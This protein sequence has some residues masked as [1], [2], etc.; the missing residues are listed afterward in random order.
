[1]GIE[2][3]LYDSS[4]VVQK[5]FSHILYHYK[6][7]VHRMD[8]VPKLL[9]TIQ[10]NRPDIIFMDDEFSQDEDL[11]AQIKNKQELQNIPIIFMGNEEKGPKASSGRNFLKKPISA[12]QLRTLIHQFVPKTKTH[13]LEKHLTFPALP[14]FSEEE[15]L[16]VDE[17]VDI[18][19]SVSSLGAM[20]S[21]KK[22]EEGPAFPSL[23]PVDE[24]VDPAIGRFGEEKKNDEIDSIKTGVTR[25]PLS[26]QT[27]EETSS[28]YQAEEEDKEEADNGEAD[29]GEADDGEADDGEA[30]DGEA[31]G[32][33]PVTATQ[34]KEVS[35]SQTNLTSPFSAGSEAEP[36]AEPSPE[37]EPEAEV[38]PSTSV[39]EP[40][41]EE[42]GVDSIQIEEP[43]SEEEIKVQGGGEAIQPES[44][45]Q[46]ESSIPVESSA[47]VESSSVP[48][49]ELKEQVKK[50][51]EAFME[52][53]G[54]EIAQKTVEKA[55]WEVVPEL[56][57]QMVSSAL[58]QL[59]KEEEMSQLEEES[60]TTD[61]K[62]KSSSEE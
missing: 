49:E 14:D 6:P 42:E 45:A 34:Y 26:S 38:S 53:E 30:D 10:H 31:D 2:I 32:I 48:V 15:D 19:S 1:M 23:A 57:R 27:S 50:E 59:L 21:E 40:L 20:A 25:S 60:K 51:V 11:Q 44:S 56:A 46:A 13:I 4:P 18:L 35:F 62:N 52:R 58:D 33:K 5:I 55:V 41:K 28:F 17:P 61:M 37:V 9:E 24:G 47:Q 39:I 43:S 54:K 29:D 12:E 16:S 36:E 3:V 22:E 8:Q 7:I